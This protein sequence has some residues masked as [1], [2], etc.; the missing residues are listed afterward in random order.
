MCSKAFRFVLGIG[1]WWFCL[2]GWAAVDGGR[3]VE[4][5][6]TQV[7]VTLGYDPAYRRIAYPGGDVPLA[8]G[9]CTDV[10]IRA[11][12][13]QGLDLQQ[14]VHEDMRR[15]FSAYPRHWGL[16]RPDPNIDHR[17]VPNLMTWF[18]RQGLSLKVGQAAADYQPGDIVT[19]DLGRGLQHI[20]IISDRRSRE[21]TPLA[22]HNIG[23]G[24]R[25]EDI[26]FRWPILGH[27]RFAAH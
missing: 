22:L 12:R 1:L 26:L 4:A 15:H 23:Q 16:K 14:R 24:T 27:Y 3:L 11:L 13:A 25:E 10:V 18:D 7:G 8:T 5:A 17:R 6:R 20:G 19:W 21:G 9:V 2:A